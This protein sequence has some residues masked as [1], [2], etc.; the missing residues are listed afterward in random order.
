MK[1]KFSLIVAVLV[2]CLANVNAKNPL[3]QLTKIKGVQCL[4]FDSIPEGGIKLKNVNI[5]TG[6]NNELVETFD[7]KD[8]MILITE[9]K[10]SIDKLFTQ[11]NDACKQNGYETLIN[12]ND[13]EDRVRIYAQFSDSRCNIAIVVADDEDG[14]VLSA[15]VKGN[16]ENLMK[17]LEQMNG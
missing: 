17:M 1:I 7:P 10:E 2:M 14:V 11:A 15:N 12:V 8:I 5:G 13:G 3:A 9:K 16:K 4:Q 6:T